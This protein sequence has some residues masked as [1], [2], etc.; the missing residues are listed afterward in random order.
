MQEQ[1]HKKI[2]WDCKPSFEITRQFVELC[3]EEALMVR[4]AVASK[5][6]EIA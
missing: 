5:I 3:K 6:G 2:L 1:E 4:R